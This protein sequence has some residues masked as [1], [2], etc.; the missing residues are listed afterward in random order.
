MTVYTV[1]YVN[2]KGLK[3]RVL[4]RKIY[5][6]NTTPQSFSLL[7]VVIIERFVVATTTVEVSY[8][9]IYYLSWYFYEFLRYFGNLKLLGH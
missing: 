6:K 1:Y 4:E 5:E 8:H 3:E 9:G 7:Y 2:C